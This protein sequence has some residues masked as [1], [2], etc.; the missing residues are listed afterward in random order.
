MKG[1]L[2]I[3]FPIYCD[4]NP[5]IGASLEATKKLRRALG[6]EGG[7]AL[8][9]ILPR[10]KQYICVTQFLRIAPHPGPA[11]PIFSILVRFADFQL[12][13]LSV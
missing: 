2:F 4:R 13:Q 10:E 1:N 7:M 11:H 12:K 3:L 9:E 6:K 5:Q 8:P